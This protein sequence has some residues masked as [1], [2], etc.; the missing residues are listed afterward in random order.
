MRQF[1]VQLI[2]DRVLRLTVRV[3]PNA[4]RESARVDSSGALRLAVRAKPVEGAA[5]RAVETY[6]AR[7]FGVPKRRVTVVRGL[8]ARDKIVAVEGVAETD[9]LARLEALAEQPE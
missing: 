3:Q 4:S 6:V 5:N 1:A 2:K 7:L 8:R 9:A